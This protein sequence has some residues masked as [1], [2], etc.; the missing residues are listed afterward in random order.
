[1]VI[2]PMLVLLSESAMWSLQFGATVTRAMLHNRA[3]SG[4]NHCNREHVRQCRARVSLAR[5]MVTAMPL[6]PHTHQER[7]VAE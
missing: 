1:M 5:S 3:K 6:S 4:G 7:A 2:C